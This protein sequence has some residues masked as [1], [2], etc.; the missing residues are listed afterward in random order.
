[1][2]SEGSRDES[3]FYMDRRT[4]KENPSIAIVEGRQPRDME[5]HSLNLVK[6][7]TALKEDGGLGKM[8]PA[9]DCFVQTPSFAKWSFG[10][11]IDRPPF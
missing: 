5:Q 7:V 4:R 2:T 3:S 10:T 6:V 9:Q 8:T 11:S 1:M